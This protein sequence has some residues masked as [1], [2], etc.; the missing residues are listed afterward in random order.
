LVFITFPVQEDERAFFPSTIDAILAS[1][2]DAVLNLKRNNL[3]GLYLPRRLP[4]LF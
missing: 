4:N 3:H 1:Q 2:K